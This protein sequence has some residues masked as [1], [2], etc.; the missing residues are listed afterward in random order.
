MAV[1]H[2]LTQKGNPGNPEVRKDKVKSRRAFQKSTDGKFQKHA[3]DVKKA[4]GLS[5][6]SRR[7]F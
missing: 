2:V 7:A 6:K 3:C 5:G 1:T 4:D